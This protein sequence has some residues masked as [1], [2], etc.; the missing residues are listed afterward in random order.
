MK[1]GSEEDKKEYQQAGRMAK[2]IRRRE[3]RNQLQMK[4][5]QLEESYKTKELRH[6]YQ[7]VNRGKGQ[8]Q[9]PSQYLKNKE[10]HLIGDRAGK[11][12]RFAL[13]FEELLNRDEE[14]MSEAER[15]LEE[16]DNSNNTNSRLEKY[17]N[18]DVGESRE[19]LKQ[20]GRQLTKLLL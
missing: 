12:N 4:L 20:A 18:E 3:K 16:E 14:G 6:F 2:K 8:Q 1:E 15:E 9:R 17:Q 7:E 11:C 13:Y 19:D 10:G 5:K